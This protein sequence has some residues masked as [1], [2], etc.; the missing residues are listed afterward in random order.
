MTK[1]MK[2][3]V[4]IILISFIVLGAVNFALADNTQKDS[5][6]I[7]IYYFYGNTCPVCKKVSYLLE[8]FKKE[9]PLLKINSY[10]VFG[11][12]ENAKF[13]IQLLESCG[14]EKIVRVPVIFIGDEIIRGYLNDETTGQI[15][16]KAI[17]NCLEEECLNP[18]DKINKCDLCECLDNEEFCD[19]DEPCACKEDIKNDQ[20]INYPF[21]GEINL[22]KISLPVLTILVAALDGFNPCAMWVLLFLIALLINVKSR[23]KMWI[24]GGTFI[25]VSGIVYYLLLTAWLNLFLAISYVSIT[26]IIIGFFAVALGFYQIKNFIVFKPG[27]CKVAPVGGK[28]NKHLSEKA[29]QVVQSTALPVTFIGIVILALGVNLVEFFCSAGLP[30]IYTNILSLSDLNSL[31]YYLYLLLYTIVFMLD[32]MIIFSIAIITLSKIGFTDKYTKWSMLIGGLLIL[33]LGI[34]LIF[35]PDLLMFG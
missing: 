4:I 6:D 20:I 22:S 16:E 14:E 32:D 26:R 11:N 17:R 19:C 30:A 27:V 29:K 8:E 7:E 34:L 31:S 23:K 35:R 9:Y 21:I 33:I 1:F 15:I 24:I 3:F 5:E 10:E 28:L 12:K 13:F 2:K 25:V 18:L